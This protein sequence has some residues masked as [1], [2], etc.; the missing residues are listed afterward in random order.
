MKVLQRKGL[1]GRDEASEFGDKGRAIMS[2][3]ARGEAGASVA[4]NVLLP[5]GEGSSSLS[6]FFFKKKKSFAILPSFYEETA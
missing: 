4:Q 1:C 6:C 3:V 2:E 5:G